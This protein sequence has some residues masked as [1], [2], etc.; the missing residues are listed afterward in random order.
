M[1][2]DSTFTPTPL[3]RARKAYFEQMIKYLH[4]PSDETRAVLDE[5]MKDYARH[6]GILLHFEKLTK[7]LTELERGYESAWDAFAKEAQSNW[8]FD[9]RKDLSELFF[10]TAHDRGLAK[11]KW[12]ICS[13]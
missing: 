11:K 5:M 10:E 1:K 3:A 4:S 6:S 7:L 9:A 13:E 12:V 2:T 8:F